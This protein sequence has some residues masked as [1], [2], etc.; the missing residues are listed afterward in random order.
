MP[1]KNQN[2]HIQDMHIPK[3][4]PIPHIKLSRPEAL[5]YRLSIKG[6]KINNVFVKLVLLKLV[7]SLIFI[8]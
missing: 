7:L 1:I 6:L 8:A 2:N 4:V 3:A 5:I